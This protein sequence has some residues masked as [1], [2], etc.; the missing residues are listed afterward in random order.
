MKF[1]FSPAVTSSTLLLPPNSRASSLKASSIMS[2]PEAGDFLVVENTLPSLSFRLDSA[3]NV[4]TIILKSKTRAEDRR[5]R[6]ER[7]SQIRN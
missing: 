2:L 7:V 1:S 6:A 3:F 4:F 5:L